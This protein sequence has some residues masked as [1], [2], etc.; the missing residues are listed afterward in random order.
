MKKEKF[1]GEIRIRNVNAAAVAR[2]T[3]IA[4][5]SGFKSRNAYLKHYIETLAVIPELRNVENRY[6]SL[7]ENVIT[8][9]EAQT[10]IIKELK[11][12]INNLEAKLN[13]QNK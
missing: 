9:L 8:V 10:A 11:I 4:K 12:E 6:A 2:I 5:Q 3:Q 13:E 1:V 7:T